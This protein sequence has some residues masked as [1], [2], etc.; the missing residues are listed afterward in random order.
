[1]RLRILLALFLL[2]SFFPLTAFAQS[3]V[4][5]TDP[6]IG[7]KFVAVPAGS[8]QM[9]STLDTTAQP[10]HKVSIKPFLIG[11]Y[12]VTFAEY[13]QFCAATRRELPDDGGW[14]MGNRPVINVSWD[15][16]VA[17]TDW[18]SAKSGRK[19]RLPSEAEWEYAA[20]G[21]TTT[22]FP[23][24]PNL[25][26]NRAN[27]NGCGSVWDNKSTAPVASFKPN[28]YGLYDVIGNVYEWCLDLQHDNY[29][30]APDD[31][32][33]WLQPG[34]SI[35]RVYRGAA[36]NQPPVEMPVSRRCWGLPDTRDTMTGFRV[37]LEP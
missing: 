14:G 7:M 10:V 22:P 23:W 15:D 32:S 2:V 35:E 1:M 31:G 34:R 28:G 12:E 29:Q 13:A 25:G 3:R 11:L 24:G 27:C 5:Y 26:K 6:V 21:G 8:Y 33:P 16:A 36:F 18:L 19:F 20:R 17:F 37:L 4:A 30:G 9:G